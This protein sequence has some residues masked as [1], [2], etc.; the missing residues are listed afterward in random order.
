[1]LVSCKKE[2]EFESSANEIKDTIATKIEGSLIPFGDELISKYDFVNEVENAESVK[3]KRENLSKIT[4]NYQQFNSWDFN[5]IKKG[6]IGD[7]ILKF[8]KEKN[9]NSDADIYIHI[10]LLTIKDNKKIDEIIVYKNEN[11]SE[12]LAAVSEYLSLIHI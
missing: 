3:L 5:T 6:N 2:N 12:A 9:D 7:I 10:I 11:Y 8:S 1:M 4:F